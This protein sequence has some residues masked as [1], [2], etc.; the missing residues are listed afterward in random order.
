MIV[1]H[2]IEE[3]VGFYSEKESELLKR[4]NEETAEKTTAYQMLSG[5][6]QGRFL[7]LISKM[8]Q[9]KIILEI[10][11]FTGYSALCLAEGL[12]PNGILYTID[13]DKYV[14]AIA[15]KYFL[16][17]IYANQI[18]S[19]LGNAKEKI[20]AIDEKIDLAFIDAD[21]K[22]YAAYFD[23]ILP[24]MNSGG[25]IIADNILW[26]GKVLEQE[27]DN[28]TQAIHA[29]NQKIAEEQKV[30]VVVLPIRDGLS[31]IRVK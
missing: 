8:I 27:K 4:L 25:I 12:K 17:S 7:A 3:Y 9:P 10:G 23:M 16:E 28:R 14:Q 29:F 6:Y 21:K 19:I 18:I 1:P 13:T 2:Q 5:E 22:S 20:G 26:K 30:E 11:T 24:M 15:K 31:I